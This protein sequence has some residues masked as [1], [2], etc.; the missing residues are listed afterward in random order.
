MSDFRPYSAADGMHDEGTLRRWRMLRFEQMPGLTDEERQQMRARRLGV[1]PGELSARRAQRLAQLAADAEDAGLI[2]ADVTTETLVKVALSPDDRP[3]WLACQMCMRTVHKRKHRRVEVR[4]AVFACRCCAYLPQDGPP[5]VLDRWLLTGREYK[6]HAIACTYRVDP[7]RLVAAEVRAEVFRLRTD[8]D[9]LPLLV[10]T[11]PAIPAAHLVPVRTFFAL[12][13]ERGRGYS[14]SVRPALG[15]D[16]VRL[17]FGLV[18]ADPLSA[19]EN[20]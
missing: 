18:I 8:V 6:R 16:S 14:D 4:P 15:R 9:G 19:Q 2:P 11:S 1:T 7:A 12:V 17:A 13:R 20:P 10:E 3:P 5:E